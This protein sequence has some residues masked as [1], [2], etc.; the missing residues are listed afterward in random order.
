[1][2]SLLQERLDVECESPQVL[3]ERRRKLYNYLKS[4]GRLYEALEL[5]RMELKLG[6]ADLDQLA[7]LE[8]YLEMCSEFYAHRNY[9]NSVLILYPQIPR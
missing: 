7:I 1:M 5:A 4:R 2:K 9:K 8:D 3:R 6:T